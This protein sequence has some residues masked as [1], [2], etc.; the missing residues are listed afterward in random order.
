MTSPVARLRLLTQDPDFRRGAQD[1][2][3]VALGIAAFGLVTG[4][5]M[6][7]S[8]MGVANAVLLSLLVFAG[9]AQLAVTPL[10]ASGAPVWVVWATALC[11]NLRFLV[12]SAQWRPYFG[13]LPL[14]TRLWVMY[15]AADLNLVMFLKRYPQPQ[16]E[17]GQLRYFW[18]GAVLNAG[19][20]H[21]ASLLGITLG[22]RVPDAWGLGF[23]G[24]VALLAIT[25]GMLSEQRTWLP[26][27]VAA[28]VALAWFALPLKLHMLLAIAAAVAV[29]ALVDRALPP[30][31]PP[32][33]PPQEPPQ[34]PPRQAA[35]EALHPP[36]QQPAQAAP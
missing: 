6:S 24:T 35:S 16:A 11:V 36:A 25:V 14:R 10:M 12:F 1:M 21:I 13:H 31:K 2:A 22:H 3:S 8:G 33:Q 5:A 23:A 20:W 26:A 28:G 19:S 30:A 4:V 9:S 17:A 29:G 7:R 34:Q 18:G 15:W 27:L 32:Q